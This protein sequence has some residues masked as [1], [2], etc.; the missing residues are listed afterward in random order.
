MKPQILAA[1]VATTVAIPHAAA[2]QALA[3]AERK[4]ADWTDAHWK[5]SLPLLERLVNINSGSLNEA[6]VKRVA[7]VLAPEFEKLGFTVRWSPLPDSVHRAGHLIAERKGSHGKKLLLIGHLDTVFEESS[8]FQKYVQFGD[9]LAAG[10]GVQDMKGGDLV[11]LNALRAM[12]AAGALDGTTITVVLT[13]DEESPG[14]PLSVAR[15]DLIEAGKASD[16]ALEFEG[17]NQDSVAYAT[18]ARRSSSDFTLDVTGRRAHSSGIFT[19]GVGAGA[20]FEAARILNEF[21]TELGHEHYLTFSPGVILGGSDVAYDPVEAGGTAAGKTN[22]VAEK[23]H[24]EGNIRTISRE[25]LERTRQRMRDIVARHLPRTD[26]KITFRDDY[27]AM[28]PTEGNRKLLAVYDVGSRALGLGK[29]LAFDPGKR[30]AADIEFVARYTD[31][32]G[33]LGPLGSGSHTDREKLDLRSMAP[34]I[35]RAAVLM[36]RLTR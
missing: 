18:I 29:V 35:K 5:E 7:G 14:D 26:A 32:L 27:P 23:A 34:T 9:T 31:G 21:Y 2:A 20:I 4:M 13:G 6:G 22:V 19:P 11:I 30:G 10:P 16:V 8:P 1:L 24:V 3:P 28:P 25:Q 17:G 36:Y 15:R 12:D 33:G